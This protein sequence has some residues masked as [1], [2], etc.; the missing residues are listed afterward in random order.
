[1]SNS[2]VNTL[3]QV[4]KFLEDKKDDQ[5]LLLKVTRIEILKKIHSWI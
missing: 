1:M 2:V 5:F 4:E 3:K